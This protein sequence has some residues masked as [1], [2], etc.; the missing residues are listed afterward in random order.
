MLHA[1]IVIR[2]LAAHVRADEK[3]FCGKLRRGRSLAGKKFWN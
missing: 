3:Y 2:K 1:K